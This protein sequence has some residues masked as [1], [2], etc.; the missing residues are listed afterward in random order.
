MKN[1]GKGVTNNITLGNIC[2]LLKT[3][4]DS[5]SLFTEE[6][7]NILSSPEK[8]RSDV[9]NAGHCNINVLD[10]TTADHVTI[11]FMR[12]LLKTFSHLLLF[13]PDYQLLVEH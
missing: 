11:F 8:S 2:R 5:Y 12:S 10:V 13:P 7:T 9:I 3:N 1:Y 6:F 4:I